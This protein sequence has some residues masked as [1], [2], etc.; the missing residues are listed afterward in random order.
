VTHAQQ[1][2]S[3]G[4]Q[5]LWYAYQQD[6]DSTA[7]NVAIAL[8][9]RSAVREDCLVS[10][11][12]RLLLRHEQLRSSFSALAEGRVSRSVA[13]S[14]PADFQI[15][16][17]TGA[18]HAERA[19][20][21]Q[22]AEHP[23]PAALRLRVQEFVARPFVLEKPAGACRGAYF[24]QSADD[25][26]LVL[27]AH[28]IVSDFLSHGLLVRD[29]LLIYQSLVSGRQDA[30][31][32]PL[33]AGYDAYCRAEREFSGDLEDD[34][35][36]VSGPVALPGL[37]SREATEGTGAMESLLPPGLMARLRETA[38]DIGTSVYALL[39]TAFQQVISSQ[40]GQIHFGVVCPM[41]PPRR[42]LFPDTVG[43]FV[44]PTLIRSDGRPEESFS[45]AAR[46][47]HARV[48]AGRRGTLLSAA[49][50]A[51][52]I[53]R[54]IGGSL[55]FG[56]Q[57]TGPSNVLL[58]LHARGD[59]TAGLEFAGLRL[60]A[61][62]IRQ[63]EGQFDLTVEV[64]ETSAEAKIVIRYRTSAC[65]DAGAKL[66]AAR[67]LALLERL[68]E[69]ARTPLGQLTVV[70]EAERRRLESWSRGVKVPVPD[71]QVH[72]TIAL[73][74]RAAPDA[75]A[76][77]FADG[78]WTY[79]E[80]DARADQVAE[81]L[82][83]RGVV[84]GDRVGLCL[85]RS[86]RQLSAM[87][88][89]LRAGAAFLPLDPR[90]P[91]ERLTFMAAD[92]AVSCVLTTEELSRGHSFGAAE[93]VLEHEWDGKA[94]SSPGRLVRGPDAYVIYTSGST[95]KP[96]G[97]ATSHRALAQLAHWQRGHFG[98]GP[99]DVVLRFAPASFDAFVW[100]ALLA[101]TAGAALHVPDPET[102]LA[103]RE[104][105][106]VIQD[107]G[108]TH[109]ALPPS[110]LSGL[111]P[112]R[113]AGLRDIVVAGEEFPPGLAA[114]WAGEGRAVWNV[115]GQTETAICATIRRVAGTESYVPIGGPIENVEIDVVD[116]DLVAVPIGVP[117]EIMVSG[118]AVSAGYLNRPEL[119]RRSFPSV[120]PRRYL[121]GD[122]GCWTAEGELR[123]LG[124][125]DTQVKVRGFRVEPGEIE[126]VLEGHPEVRDVAV[127]T[128]GSEADRRLVAFV[129]GFGAVTAVTELRGWLARR[130]PAQLVPSQVVAL[131]EMPRTANGKI[132]R[133][134][135]S[136]SLPDDWEIHFAQP[137]PG[138]Q[139]DIAAIWSE[140]LGRPI[141]GEDDF[142]A[143][144]GHSLMAVEMVAL[145]HE[146]LNL[147]VPLPMVFSHPTVV[148][149]AENIGA[150]T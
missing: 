50:L 73:R 16:D 59:E 29:F 4:Q 136:G 24:R 44:R 70:T 5:D 43:Y 54:G 128:A 104:L 49:E 23:A 51:A 10:A 86:P 93:A 35:E 46:R 105:E 20:G 2:V 120:S 133:K 21:G 1:P 68:P 80:L 132:D 67:Y 145:L 127:V 113:V 117:G 42:R 18:D 45:D 108:V 129:T 118:G 107:G 110:V 39:L 14:W 62:R 11:F 119:N 26:V 64:V 47:T 34:W 32:P 92:A 7:Y 147:E 148:A 146:R 78:Q 102:V 79:A 61:H 25:G 71:E 85:A 36:Q 84:P 122:L 72:E 3:Q 123:F 41:T 97:V 55:A 12:H 101:L 150:A 77:S 131:E 134:T 112:A 69:S 81:S 95:G 91:A 137:A 65:S 82:V 121:S 60:A 116:D 149:L 38:V 27:A 103:G 30:S 56:Y 66:V 144:G 17:L 114:R 143:S 83:G 9:V 74:A 28:H 63:Q 48:L 140:L 138:L 124:R 115:Y 98:A 6:P 57:R 13:V 111:D 53:G 75:P 88:G 22:A 99:G 126:T 94:D 141:G 135:L 139:S 76:V 130:L 37:A 40:S 109:A 58:D 8:R 96:K 52:R 90:Y 89:I 19:P 15:H 100:E 87:L 142:F 106:A 31:L 125:R 33:D